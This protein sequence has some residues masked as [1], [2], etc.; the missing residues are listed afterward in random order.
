MKILT[1]YWRQKISCCKRPLIR[2]NNYVEE[3]L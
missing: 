3:N 1:L 2:S